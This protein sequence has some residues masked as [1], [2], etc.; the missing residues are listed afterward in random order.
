MTRFERTAGNTAGYKPI[1]ST[2]TRIGSHGYPVGT[3]RASSPV[4]LSPGRTRALK[5]CPGRDGDVGPRKTV[6]APDRWDACTY[7][8][9]GL[10]RTKLQLS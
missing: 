8:A 1:S 6:V 2:T 5:S 7:V 4:D 3:C 10:D 9:Y